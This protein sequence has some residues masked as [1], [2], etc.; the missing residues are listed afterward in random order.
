MKSRHLRKRIMRGCA[1]NIGVD[2]ILA[3][4]YNSAG[5]AFCLACSA[6]VSCV[7]C[8]YAQKEAKR[9]RFTGRCGGMVY[10]LVS[11]TSPARGEG[12]NLSIGTYKKVRGVSSRARSGLRRF[13][14]CRKTPL[15]GTTPFTL[16]HLST[17]HLPYAFPGYHSIC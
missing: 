3:P 12:S 6:L 14:F 15:T 2:S 13:C 8:K 7:F 9:T 16:E 17:P 10:A 4:C 11:K 5:T 1:N